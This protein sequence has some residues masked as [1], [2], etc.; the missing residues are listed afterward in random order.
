MIIIKTIHNNTCVM[1]QLLNQGI[2]NHLLNSGSHI[3]VDE[4]VIPLVGMHPV[5]KK[6]IDQVMGRINPCQCTCKT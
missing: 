4:Q 5:G 2:V 6:N 1:K 3:H